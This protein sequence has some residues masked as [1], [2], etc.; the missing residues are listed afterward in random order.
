MSYLGKGVG[1]VHELA[2][3]VGTEERIDYAADGLG[4]DK[5]SGS[6]DLIVANVHTLTDGT[7]HT[8]QADSKLVGQLLTDGTY[9]TVTQVVDIIDVSL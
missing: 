1:L 8:C 4:I 9:T 5:I 2:Q 6:E 3:C 7:A